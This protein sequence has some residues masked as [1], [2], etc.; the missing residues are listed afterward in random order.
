MAAD[1]LTK[2]VLLS[3]NPAFKNQNLYSNGL[4]ISGNTNG[5]GVTQRSFSVDLVREPDLLSVLFNGPTDTIFGS[6]P[7]PG[8]A[9][10]KDGYIWVLGTNVGDGYI[11]YPLP[12]KPE[13]RI[14]GS[15][16]T[17]ILTT[18]QQFV[19]VLTLTSTAFYYRLRDYSV[20]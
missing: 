6:D 10:F 14:D 16:A 20:F 1:D 15:S 18:V 17:I 13:V 9:W 12:F 2:L 7:R 8:S 11:D 5:S 19:S 3:E 4:V